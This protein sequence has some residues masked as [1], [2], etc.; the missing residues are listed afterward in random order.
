MKTSYGKK[1]QER[2]AEPSMY[3]ILSGGLDHPVEGDYTKSFFVRGDKP[4]AKKMIETGEVQIPN[5]PPVKKQKISLADLVKK[6]IVYRINKSNSQYVSE[7]HDNF[8]Q[9]AYDKQMNQF[10]YDNFFNPERTEGKAPIEIEE[11]FTTVYRKEYIDKMRKLAEESGYTLDE[12]SVGDFEKENHEN[13]NKIDMNKLK[14]SKPRILKSNKNS[15]ENNKNRN[16]SG[17][18]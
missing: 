5:R 9:Y 8:R 7:S 1:N 18:K 11:W 3:D 16:K 17:S 14:N 13:V 10:I 6:D 15:N 4:F 2:E 12:E